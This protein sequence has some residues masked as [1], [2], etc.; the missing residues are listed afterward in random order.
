MRLQGCKA[1]AAVLSLSVAAAAEVIPQGTH[2]LL[3]MLNSVSTRTVQEGDYV[4]M[5]TASPITAQGR[6]IVP[7]GSYVQGVVSYVQRAGRVKGRA[8]L[9]IRLETLTLPRGAVVR[10]SPRLESVDPNETDQRVDRNQEAITQP[11]GVGHDAARI[12]IFAGSGAA[13]GGVVDR[14]WKG[15]GIGAGVGG[16]VGLATVLL[17]RGRPAEL[18]RGATLDVVF[19]RPVELK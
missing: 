8:A 15:A 14:G 3:R 9:G 10:F 5:R 17:S 13:L 11:S 19:E 2:V 16:G 1:A 7:V 6:I 12:A 4:Y 18:R